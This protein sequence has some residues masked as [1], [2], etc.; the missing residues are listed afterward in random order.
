MLRATTS[1]SDILNALFVWAVLFPFVPVL[2]PSSDTQPTFLLVL[3]LAMLISLAFPAT[4][5]RLFRLSLP[6]AI[7]ATLVAVGVYAC[8]VIANLS[9]ADSTIPSRLISFLQF[10]A[11][12]FWA[13][14]G[15]HEWSE[16][17]LFRAL[18]IYAVF[19]VI[20][21]ATGGII[22]N[23]LIHS[24]MENAEILFAMGRG[25][26]T[27]SPEPSF[28]ALQVF[29]IF[30]LARILFSR[31]HDGSV[32]SLRWVLI[33]GFCLAASFSA[34]GA[35]L[36]VLVVLAVYPR[37]FVLVAVLAIASWGILSRYMADWDSV[38]A[39]KVLFAL[40]Q[41]RG[42]LTDLTS[43]DASLSSRLVSFGDYVRSFGRNPFFG[44][45]FSLYQGGG[46][47]SIVAALG[48]A[49]LGFF[50]AVLRKIVMMPL[51]HRTKVIL[52]IWFAMN[53]IS[54]P[55]GIPIIGVVVGTLLRRRSVTRPEELQRTAPTLS[56]VVVR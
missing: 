56:L 53:F 9:R 41:A 34:Y 13:Y 7:A 36:L 32:N 49:A 19:T 3:L 40:V 39:V 17:V 1:T 55:I 35:I 20:Y 23:T 2:I 21:F 8:L 15:K 47:V 46:F 31:A 27:L 52:L 54:G 5:R 48:L 51:D 43:L 37:L 24:R 44:D 45:G 18:V 30:V 28:F 14:A 26:R 33:T 4:G 38:R 11:A 16:K 25:A 29:N 12:A 6:G 42:S 22:E 50:V 10:S